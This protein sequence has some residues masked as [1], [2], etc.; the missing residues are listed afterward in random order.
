M[1]RQVKGHVL[2]KPI[3]SDD[4]YEA[5]ERVEEILI[6]GGEVVKNY[7]HSVAFAAWRRLNKWYIEMMEMPLY[8]IE[9]NR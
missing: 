4:V 6:T 3:T 9:S 1:I 8:G 7:D 2:Q 5:I